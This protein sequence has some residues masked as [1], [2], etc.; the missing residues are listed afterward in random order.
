MIPKS[1]ICGGYNVIVELGC[2]PGGLAKMVVV[3]G[4]ELMVANGS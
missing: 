1:I 3:F 2:C 4:G